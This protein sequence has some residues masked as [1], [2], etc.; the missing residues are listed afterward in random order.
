MEKGYEMDFPADTPFPTTLKKQEAL[1]LFNALDIAPTQVYRG[2]TDLMVALNSEYDVKTLSPDFRLLQ[3]IDTRGIIVTAPGD[4][5][6]FVS[7]FFAPQSG[8]DE[9]PVTGSAHTTLVPFWAAQLGKND[10]QAQQLS[11]RGGELGCSLQGE[12]V[13][14]RGDAFTVLEGKFFLYW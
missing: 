14:L 6:D 4:L 12:R 10:L 8:I 9:D 7:R 5:V 13:K 11:V 2:V 3:D 1:A